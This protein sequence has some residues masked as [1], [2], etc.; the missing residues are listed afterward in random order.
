MNLIIYEIDVFKTR[1]RHAKSS[2][3]IIVNVI[4]HRKESVLKIKRVNFK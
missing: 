3:A 4:F 1:T 2:I